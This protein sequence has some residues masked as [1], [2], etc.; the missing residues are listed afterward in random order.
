MLLASFKHY[1]YRMFFA[2]T[3][4]SNIGTWN[5]RL[6]QDWLVL[7]LTGSAKSLGLVVA[8]QFLPGIFFAIYGGVLA[9]KFDLRRILKAC[10]IAGVV[11]ALLLGLAVLT[12]TANFSIVFAAAFTLGIATAIEGPVRQSYYVKLVGDQDLPNALSWNQINL[13]FGRLAGPLIAGLLIEFV[14]MAPAFFLNGMTYLIAFLTLV[15]MKTNSYIDSPVEHGESSDHTLKDA[16]RYLV[17]NRKALLSIS[18][19][20]FAAFLGQDMQVT[21]AIMVKDEFGGNAASLGALGAIFAFGAIMG[22]LT[23]ARKKFELTILFLGKRVIYVSVVWLLAALSPN[24]LTFAALL[25]AVGF[26]SMGVNISGNMSVRTFVAPWFYG[27]VWG[28]YIALWLAA[29]ALGAPIIGLISEL[30]S[31]RIAIGVGGITSA[32]VGVVTIWAV[33]RR[34]QWVN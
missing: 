9:D 2:G 27:K 34:P 3:A 19:V 26:F 6:A 32:I 22:S 21:S 5:H 18:I 29:L 28:I 13:Y 4:I 7:E 17:G 20:S 33:K 15:V 14:G 8:A 25:F 10:N 11:L 1:N 23:H 12:E 24:Y 30:T 16:A 31:A